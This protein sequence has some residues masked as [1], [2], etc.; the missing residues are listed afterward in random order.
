MAKRRTLLVFLIILALVSGF[1]AMWGMHNYVTGFWAALALIT[2]PFTIIL[3][4]A[5]VAAWLIPNAESLKN[6]PISIIA[7]FFAFVL[8][9]GLLRLFKVNQTYLERI[10]R[11]EYQSPFWPDK[12][13]SFWHLYQ[14]NF[15]MDFDRGEFW[16]HRTTNSLGITEREINLKDT[17]KVKILCLGDSFTEGIG[18]TADSSWPRFL[19]RDLAACSHDSLIVYN[20]GVAG[21]EPVYEYHLLKGK[22]W[23]VNWRAVVFNINTTDV[24]ECFRRGGM[25]RF[26]N[27]TVQFR[28]PPFWEPAYA[29]SRL[30]RFVMINLLDYNTELYPN[31]Q[32]SQLKLAASDT[33]FTVLQ[34][35]N[36]EL[37]A[38]G[39]KMFVIA[40]PLTYD[41]LAHKY[42]EPGFDNIINNGQQINLINLLPYF[43]DSL[44]YNK[45]NYTQIY[46]PHDGH[47]NAKGYSLFARKIA[48]K[49]E[50]DLSIPGCSNQ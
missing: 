2:F 47:F 49:L 15:T 34:H 27:D 14:P 1:A 20:A 28:Q 31:S 12:K 35:A 38:R 18:T 17:T 33:I 40:A 3:I 5:V 7:L 29:S 19:E 43:T 6:I 44:G 26:R 39:I 22:L 41:V 42:T 10:G 25:G 37:S 50:A 48:Q 24:L 8:A 32:C 23:D 45:N 11:T 9:E 13:N 21:S 36:A 4:I 16:Y 46:W 30:F